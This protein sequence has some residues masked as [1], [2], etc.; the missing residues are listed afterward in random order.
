MLI[1]VEIYA[2][3]ERTKA[4]AHTFCCLIS[5]IVI[6]SGFDKQDLKFLLSPNKI[7]Q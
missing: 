4:I 5:N 1:Y 7:I 2:N 6:V 3:D